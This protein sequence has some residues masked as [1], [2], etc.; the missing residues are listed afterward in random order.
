M[1]A[2]ASRGRRDRL[3]HSARGYSA[4][5]VTDGRVLRVIG[6]APSCWRARWPA[7]AA[8]DGAAAG[9]PPELAAGLAARPARARRRRR[10][11]PHLA[12]AGRPAR[13]SS[14]R[15]RG[16]HLRRSGRRQFVLYGRGPLRPPRPDHLQPGR[17][18]ADGPP[19]DA[20]PDP[21]RAVRRRRPAT[22]TCRPASATPRPGTSTRRAITCCRSCWRRPGSCS[23]SPAC[24]RRMWCS[25]RPACSSCSG[26]PAGSSGRSG[27][28]SS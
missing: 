22:W 17:P 14:R 5:M 8:A 27:P 13:P 15:R 28:S 23:A 18:L 12:R 2:T 4:P 16:R 3:V 20:D 21:A 7:R 9:R 24:S 25:P 11:L 1:S 10:G 26:W 19:A 6:A